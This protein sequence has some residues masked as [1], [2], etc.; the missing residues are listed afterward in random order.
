MPGAPEYGHIV[1]G[2]DGSSTSRHALVWAA[3]EAELRGCPL[4]V[5]YGWQVKDEP[6]PPGEWGGVAPPA[7]AYQEAAER[8]IRGVVDEV[9]PGGVRCEIVVHAV[10]KSPG[11]ALLSLCPVADLLVVGSTER[12]RLVSWL[13]GSVSGEALKNATC[14][15]VVVRPPVEG[16]PAEAEDLDEQG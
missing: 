2:V 6:R 10:H 15:V 5:V 16:P 9:L 4:D 3:R 1:V 8:R 11:R 14:T 7:E 12:G 13:V